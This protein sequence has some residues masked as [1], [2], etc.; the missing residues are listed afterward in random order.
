MRV[1]F[2]RWKTLSEAVSALPSG[3]A[4]T[5]RVGSLV[6]PGRVG[7][8]G[9]IESPGFGIILD[10]EQREYPFTFDVIVRYR[11]ESAATLGLTMGKQVKF[12]LIDEK[13]VFLE[14]YIPSA[15][16][17]AVAPAAPAL[18]RS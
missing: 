7:L 1:G 8:I 17:S 18:S 14:P 3:P 9:R 11:G 2:L 4:G 5:V 13:V 6:V 10:A 15:P 16:S 12:A